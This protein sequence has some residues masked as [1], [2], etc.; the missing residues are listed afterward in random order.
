MWTK[1]TKGRSSTLVWLLSLLILLQAYIATAAPNRCPA[2]RPSPIVP[3]PT[4]TLAIPTSITRPHLDDTMASWCRFLI[5]LASVLRLPE[6][7]C[8]SPGSSPACTITWNGHAVSGKLE[9]GVCKTT[10]RYG[11]AKRWEDSVAATTQSGISA[12]EAP[13]SCPQV[14][15]NPTQGGSQSEDCL[16]ATIYAPVGGRRL[17]VFVW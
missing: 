11:S 3:K 12:T 4:P 9:G 17:P 15:P 6:P 10:V 7:A 5:V 16:T 2:H 14:T 8:A 13:P 1:A